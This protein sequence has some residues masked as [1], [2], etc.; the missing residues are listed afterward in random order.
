MPCTRDPRWIGGLR[1][2][3][4]F[5]RDTHYSKG[6]AQNTHRRDT[7]AKGHEPAVHAL[8]NCAV[9]QLLDVFDHARATRDG[10]DASLRIEHF[11]LASQTQATRA[12][13]LGVKVV[14]N[15]VPPSM[16]RH[17]SPRLARGRAAPLENH[18]N[19]TL[20]DA[21]AVVSA[22]SDYPCADFAP[23]LAIESAVTRRAMN[24]DRSSGGVGHSARSVAYVHISAAVVEGTAHSEGTLEPGKR[25][26]FVVLDDNPLVVDPM[27][28]HAIRVVRTYIDGDVAYDGAATES[29]AS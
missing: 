4:T 25:A 21:G 13:D 5:T 28:I 24:G 18:P 8:G 16:G 23:L 14:V 9:G 3:R 20:L 27:A 7:W 11:I 17:V 12:A 6:E 10:A 15:P 1:A 26:N 22:A 29:R 19:K 2:E